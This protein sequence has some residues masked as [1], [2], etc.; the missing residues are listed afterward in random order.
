MTVT[1]NATTPHSFCGVAWSATAWSVV[2][3]WRENREKL[4]VTTCFRLR[5]VACALGFAMARVKDS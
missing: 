4:H 3:D 2:E 1:T 5:G